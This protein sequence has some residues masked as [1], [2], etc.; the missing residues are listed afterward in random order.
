MASEGYSAEP[1][2]KSEGSRLGEHVPHVIPPKYCISYVQ[3]TINSWIDGHNAKYM[4]YNEQM[5]EHLHCLDKIEEKC[6]DKTEEK[7]NHY[8]H[9][10]ND[11]KIKLME[12]EKNYMLL[13]DERKKMIE[14][15]KEHLHWLD[16]IEEKCLDKTKEKLNHYECLKNDHKIKSK[17]LAKNYMLLSEER[18]KMKEFMLKKMALWENKHKDIIE[19]QAEV[20]IFEEEEQA[21]VNIFE[22]GNDVVD[23]PRKS[24]RKKAN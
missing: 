3:E 10:K 5:K 16:K 20:N 19:E 8:E 21:E 11:H 17:E 15:M 2:M 12:L 1:R 14:L 7:L 24:K 23:G 22:E 6:L 9:L 4:Q 13:S 18:K